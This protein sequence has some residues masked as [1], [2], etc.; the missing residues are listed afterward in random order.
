MRDHLL[1]TATRKGFLGIGAVA[2]LLA[3]QPFG[4]GGNAE[5]PMTFVRAVALT[6]VDTSSTPDTD[7]LRLAALLNQDV[8]RAEAVPTHPILLTVDG[9]DLLVPGAEVLQIGFHET[10]AD[11]HQL[12]LTPHG[13]PVANLNSHRVATPEPS[14]GG[15]YL[16]LPSRNR[17]GDP[18]SATD[19]MLRAGEDVLAPVSG[20]I[21]TAASYLLYGEHHDII[22]EIRPDDRPDLVVTMFHV[23]G[24]RVNAGQHVIAGQS[25]IADSA[26]VF[27][28]VADIEAATNTYAPHVDI[29]VRRA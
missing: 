9:L 16:V 4:A 7:V 23:D 21:V 25:V 10:T 3:S 5:L 12:H 15:N 11:R 19:V 29:R 14:K 28:F 24:V 1:L 18:M 27:P 2:A 22:V 20:T 8:E 26:R 13:E 6:D 17:D